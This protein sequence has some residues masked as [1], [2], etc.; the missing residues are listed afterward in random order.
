MK[1]MK[2]LF[3]ILLAVSYTHLNAITVAAITHPAQDCTTLMSKLPYRNA[4]NGRRT[5][6]MSS[7][8][9]PATVGGS[10]IGSVS[11]PSRTAFILGPACTDFLAA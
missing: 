4:P 1:T 2:E 5:L 6:N 9:K 7:R 11:I 10:T 8:K 3:E